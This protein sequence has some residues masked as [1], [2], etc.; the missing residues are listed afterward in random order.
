M[1]EYEKIVD[2]F[3]AFTDEIEGN[4][5][6][7]PSSRIIQ[8]TRVKFTNETKWLTDADAEMPPVELVAAD[9]LRVV[10]KWKDGNPDETIILD[11][12]QKFPDVEEMNAR[13]PQSEW[14][15]GP[16]GKRHGPWQA[17]YVVYL[18][19]PDSLDRYTYTTATVGG[20][21]AHAEFV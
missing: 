6:Q 1:S 9:I 19:N 7:K 21:N 12:G 10:Q 14:E 17:Q 15:E 3:E 13:V 20:G 8:G 4:D 2:G 16:D 18:L 5:E 11:A